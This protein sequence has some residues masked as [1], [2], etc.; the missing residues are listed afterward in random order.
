VATEYGRAG[1]LIGHVTIGAADSSLEQE[2]KGLL[3]QIDGA[4]KSEGQVVGVEAQVSGAAPAVCLRR[5]LQVFAAFPDLLTKLLDV[6]DYVTER[7]FVL[8]H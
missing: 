3:R 6:C 1:G 7:V 2:C 8:C 4:E 5:R